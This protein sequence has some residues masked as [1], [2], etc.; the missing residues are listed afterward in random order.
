MRRLSEEGQEEVDVGWSV[1]MVE[2]WDLDGWGEEEEAVVVVKFGGKRT[3]FRG[4]T[5]TFSCE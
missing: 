5:S 3:T 4:N 2:R 1:L